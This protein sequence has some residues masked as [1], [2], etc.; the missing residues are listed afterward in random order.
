MRISRSSCLLLLLLFKSF[1]LQAVENDTFCVSN[2]LYK[3]ASAV[4]S[5]T[6]VGITIESGGRVVFPDDGFPYDIGWAKSWCRESR[7]GEQLVIHEAQYW[8]DW[9]IREKFDA[10][11]LGGIDIRLEHAGRSDNNFGISLVANPEDT[12]GIPSSESWMTDLMR[13]S[14]LALNQMCIP[15]SHDTGTYD[16]TLDSAVDPYIDKGIRPVFEK[17]GE[18]IVYPVKEVI[19]AWS[20]TQTRDTYEQL[21]MGVRYLDI[22]ARRVNGQFYTAH[23]LLGATIPSILDDIRRFLDEHPKE[24]IIFHLQETTGLNQQD[25]DDLYGLL[26]K[27]FPDQLA[28]S[29]L[30]P[31]S[32]IEEFQDNGYQLIL[33]SGV[34]PNGFP[35][36]QAW[37][38]L[39]NPWYNQNTPY[40]LL[41]KLSKGIAGRSDSRFHVAQMVLTPRESD[42]ALMV[43]GTSPANLWELDNTLRFRSGFA[44]YLHNAARAAGKFSN[45]MLNDFVGTGD[46]YNNCMRENL[47]RL[48]Q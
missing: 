37:E 33:V 16:I 20:I 38:A 34:W 21:L 30:T 23:G 24:L 47:R 35:N 2:E 18:V 19:R 10:G 15:G 36:W 25:I 31:A 5:Y 7:E 22:R 12:K 26:D 46:L 4:F 41:N 28:P 14:N 48:G 8:G 6:S 3:V 40:P 13:G 11:F 32:P 1:E 29:N 9:R 42:M 39:S 17:V 44:Q 45:I 43:L 27:Y